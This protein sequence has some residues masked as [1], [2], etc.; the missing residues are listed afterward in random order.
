M[1]I[2]KLSKYFTGYL[3]NSKP[4]SISDFVNILQNNLNLE[5][6]F[7]SKYQ[8][9]FWGVIGDYE[10]LFQELLTSSEGEQKIRKIL[11]IY[12]LPQGFLDLDLTISGYW[13]K[14]QMREFKD[15]ADFRD[16]FLPWF[17]KRLWYIDVRVTHGAN[18]K[19]KDIVMKRMNE[20]G[21]YEYIAA[22]VK[23]WNL[24]ATASKDDNITTLITQAQQAFQNPYRD[25]ETNSEHLISKLLIVVSGKMT[26]SAITE[27]LNMDPKYYKNTITF[28]DGTK[29]QNLIDKLN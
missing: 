26:D 10:D 15:E 19:G 1:N 14:L 5:D 27:I 18:E 12:R 8:N 21:E 11:E 17:F 13:E 4:I 28:L 6:D 9:L 22:Q 16:N 2:K 23:Y 29:I 25:P 7:L 3:P 20:L 24:W